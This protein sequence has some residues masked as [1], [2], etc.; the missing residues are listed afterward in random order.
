MMLKE[1][2]HK[3]MKMEVRGLVEHVMYKGEERLFTGLQHLKR[4]IHP[5]H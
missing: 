2:V 3:Q 5:G 1:R 4:V